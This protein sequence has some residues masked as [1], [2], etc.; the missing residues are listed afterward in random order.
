MEIYGKSVGSKMKQIANAMSSSG[1]N[2]TLF[3]Y[4]KPLFGPTTDF[5]II[6]IFGEQLFITSF[7][8]KAS[9]F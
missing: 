2:E 1:V 3:Y 5:A 8:W 4:K 9:H 6:I 7:R